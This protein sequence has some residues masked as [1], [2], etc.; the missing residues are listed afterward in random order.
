METTKIKVYRI[1]WM[2]EWHETKEKE[3]EHAGNT[4]NNQ[5]Q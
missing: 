1:I 5:R 2:I 3:N 4:V